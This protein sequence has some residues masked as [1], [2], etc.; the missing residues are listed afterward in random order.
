MNP[1]LSALTGKG[2]AP[3][4]MMQA[5]GAALRG[6]S[7][8]TFM[9]NLARTRPE[10]NGLDL[11]NLEGTANALAQKQGKDINALTAEVKQTVSG[12]L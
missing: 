11:D 1:L 10:L 5:A 2:G 12:L 6:E 9:K 3:N 7:P 4:I 8:Q